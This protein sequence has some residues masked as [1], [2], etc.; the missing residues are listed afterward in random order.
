MLVVVLLFVSGCSSYRLAYNN[1]D[2]LLFGWVDDYVEL[3]SAQHAELEP[4]VRQWHAQH[5]QTQLPQ[6]QALLFAIRVGVQSP[7]LDPTLFEAWRV[8]VEQRGLA[9]R[10]SLAPLAVALLE[11]IDQDQQQ[12]LLGALRKKIESQRE[13]YLERSASERVGHRYDAYRERML[14]W[15][16]RLDSAQRNALKQLVALADSELQWLE[17]RSLWVDELEQALMLRSNKQQFHARIQALILSP[18][19]FRIEALQ[20]LLATTQR[21][22]SDYLVVLI[23]GLSAQQRAHLLSELDV[24]IDVIGRLIRQQD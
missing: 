21:Q 18:S 1:L 24:L 23:N 12:Q 6:Y 11:Q 20:H 2:W 3:T 4:L 22:R 17:Y 8:E 7:P 5:R 19:S 14:R 15:I 16:G 13:A 9:L 10:S